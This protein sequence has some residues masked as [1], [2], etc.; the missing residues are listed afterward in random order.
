[1]VPGLAAVAGGFLP[2]I[3]L[4][5]F[6]GLVLINPTEIHPTSAMQHQFH[7]I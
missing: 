5:L 2:V 3:G 7:N 4:P 6:T 1:V